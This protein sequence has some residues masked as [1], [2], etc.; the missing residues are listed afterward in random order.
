MQ[1]WFFFKNRH[2]Y[3]ENNKIQW[4][5]VGIIAFCITLFLEIIKLEIK[6]N[7]KIRHHYSENNKIHWIGV[8]IVGF[9]LTL[10]LEGIKLNVN[11]ISF[12]I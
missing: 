12:M 5:R 6:K 8:G 4:I 2:H 11:L 9:C 7:K 1:I 10:F 3:S